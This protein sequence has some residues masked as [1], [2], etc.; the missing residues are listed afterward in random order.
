M[1]FR[2]LRRLVEARRYLKMFFCTHYVTK[3]LGVIWLGQG[4]RGVYCEC[5]R[6]GMKFYWHGLATVLTERKGC[7]T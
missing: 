4:R 3:H 1:K 6:C 7:S 2:T 5:C